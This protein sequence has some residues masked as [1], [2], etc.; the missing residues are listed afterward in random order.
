MLTTIIDIEFFFSKSLEKS[1]E[2]VYF[3]TNLISG[4]QTS[5]ALFNT[6]LIIF[7]TLFNLQYS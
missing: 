4:A 1:L 2:K 6:P 5:C 7:K 3:L